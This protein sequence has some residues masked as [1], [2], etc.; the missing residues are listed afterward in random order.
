MTILESI[1]TLFDV[2]SKRR[3]IDYSKEIS[4]AAKFGVLLLFRD[5][6]TDGHYYGDTGPDVQWMDEVVREMGHIHHSFA[7]AINHADSFVAITEFLNRERSTVVFLD[8][9]EVSLRHW[10]APNRDNE[11]VD[12]INKVLDIHDSPYSL[13]RFSYQTRVQEFNGLEVEDI[14]AC[15]RP[16]LRQHSTIQ[17]SAIEPALD[18][19]SDPAYMTPADDFRKALSKHRTGDYDGCITSCASAVE[20]TIKVIAERNRWKINGHGLSSVA[21]SFISKSSLPDATKRSFSLLSEWRNTTSDSHGH[22]NKD[23]MTEPLARHFI[24]FAASLVVL[25][26]SESK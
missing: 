5:L 14:V 23:P 16:Y 10:R 9:L 6:N 22:T 18:L 7:G 3:D 17:D 25:A 8:F 12:A 15:P 24:A 11:F 2:A 19:F 4:D 13:T 26:Q 21:Q 1:K 20:G